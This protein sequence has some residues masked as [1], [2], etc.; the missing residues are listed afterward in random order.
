MADDL[1]A[2]WGKISLSEDEILGVDFH[3]EAFEGLV[4]K[5]QS[6]LVGKL[7]SDH[8]VSKEMIRSKLIRG[9]KPKGPMAFKVLGEN[10][11]LLKFEKNE[12]KKRVLEGRPW[13]FEGTLFSVE[14]FDGNTHP[15]DMDFSWAAFW[16]RMYKLPLAC[17]G[18]EMGQRLGASVGEVEDVDVS[19]D[20][21][22]WG[23]YLRVKIKISTLKPLAKGR[24]LRMKGK[25]IWIPFQYEKVPKYCFRCGLICHGKDGCERRDVRRKQGEDNVFEY[26]P[27]LRA[28]SPRRGM[29]R[30]RGRRGGENYPQ[31]EWGRKEAGRHWRGSRWDEFTGD[32]DRSTSGDQVLHGDLPSKECPR[33]TPTSPQSRDSLQVRK[34]SWEGGE[35]FAGRQ[36]GS[37]GEAGK[38][39]NI[40][41]K[42]PDGNYGVFSQRL[43]GGKSINEFAISFP[44][45]PDAFSATK[46]VIFGSQKEKKTGVL[47]RTQKGAQKGTRGQ[48]SKGLKV[49]GGQTMGQVGPRVA[50]LAALIA[51]HTA[52]G[53]PAKKRQR[54]ASAEKELLESLVNDGASSGELDG[55]WE[56]GTGEGNSS[57]A[58]ANHVAEA[59]D[60]P[61]RSL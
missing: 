41:G 47:T 61:R 15:T 21:E 38:G 23:E 16:V 58:G 48:V 7:L 11:F 5:G 12:D 6:C 37:A 54:N 40:L 59:I 1:A 49:E 45:D 28:T 42:E 27:W 20:G 44:T 53:P 55:K 19:E 31:E 8:V 14:D 25:E 22:G 46:G 4:Q 60:Q 29:Q 35:I 43:G 34:E 50:D 2:M 26:G 17:M 13:I 30:E 3:E 24:M 9:W 57:P 33:L 32:Y 52:T 18:K 39:K 10:L 56:I 51:Q 36:A